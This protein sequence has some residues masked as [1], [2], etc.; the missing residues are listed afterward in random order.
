MNKAA[1]HP[2][3][4]SDSSKDQF[5]LS[6]LA[7]DLLDTTWRIAI[8]VV[9][10]AGA[11]IFLDRKINSAPWFTLAGTVM[12]FVLAGVLLKQQLQTVQQ[13]EKK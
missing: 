9:L 2:T 1:D 5:S 6:T 13:E 8:P 10:F 11:G 7:L 3:T 4:K 12:G